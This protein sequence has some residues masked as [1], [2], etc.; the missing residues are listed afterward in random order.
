MVRTITTHH[1][2]DASKALTLDA[3]E[4][5]SGEPYVY[6]L[7]INGPDGVTLESGHLQFQRGPLRDGV[8]GISD[9]VLLAIIIDRLE[10][11]E[12][13]SPRG[14]EECDWAL[15]YAR[16]T[17]GHLKLLTKRRA[18]EHRSDKVSP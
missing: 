14:Y 15:T 9:E 10:H 2:H 6:V 8:N 17:M 13:A 5:D 4:D 12:R 3:V 1:T 16:A 11:A 18:K 7:G